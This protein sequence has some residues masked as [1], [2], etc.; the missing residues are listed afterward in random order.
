MEDRGPPTPVDDTPYIRFA[1]D[2]LTRDDD[3]EALQRPSTSTSDSYPVDRVIP[4]YGLGYMST[5][6]EELALTRKHRSTPTPTSQGARLFNY[7]ATRPLSRHSAVPSVIPR[8]QLLSAGPENFIPIPPPTH[9]PRHPD[10]LFLPTILRPISMITLSML[11][12]LM[13]VALM[14]LAIYSSYH[15]G[16]VE[17]GGIYGALY[18]FFAFLP[19][20]LAACIFVFVQSVM[21]AMTRI[22]PYT[23]MA[24]DDAE[25][26]ANALFLG[27]YPR[28]MLCPRWEG[29]GSIDF[30]NL[31]LFLS[32][33]T[34]PLQSCLFSV[35]QF[36]GVWKWTAVQGVAWT[37]VAI[38]ILVLLGTAI[39][40]L[41]F[42]R[43]RTGLLWDPR[44]LADII[45]LLGRSNSMEDYRDTDVIARKDQL[46]EKL[47]STPRLGYWMTQR[48]GQGIFYCIGEAGAATRRYTLD[49]G[50]LRETKEVDQSFDVERNAELYNDQTR[51]AYI[52]WYLRDTFVILW[53]VAGCLTLVALLVVSFLPSTAI[54]NGFPPLVPA[55]PNAQGYSPANFL[56]SFI[57]SVIGM[58]LYLW[59][60][61]LEMGLRKLQPWAELG[62]FNGATAD[63]SLLL[64]YT[65]E[66]PIYCTLAAFDGGHLRV[67][68]MSMLSFLFIL[69]PTISG[70]IF[71]PLTTST[72]EV[73]MI[74]N[75]PA[76]YICITLLILYM[77]GLFALVPNRRDMHLPH[78]VDCLAEIISFVHDSRILEDAAFRAPRSKADLSTRLMAAQADGRDA[79]YAFGSYTGRHGKICFGIEKLGRPNVRIQI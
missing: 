55:A 45:S 77:L 17:F 47:S 71:F 25:S 60:Q 18:F 43:R 62:E 6:R 52:A 48:K 10:L 75:R 70:G 41:F 16:L 68:I 72:D 8:R 65:A 35:T 5:H 63:R 13:T 11:C 23:L 37:L 20:I 57:P 46:R 42:F 66:L 76:F 19:Q 22:M 58:L 38:Y 50:K 74:P 64:D 2:Q 39:A 3:S 1:I 7:N 29:L 49:S 44:S 53:A 34:I 36:D 51:F 61:S 31:L 69:L 54:R 56:Y 21:S 33:F 79:R 28:T 4:D 15:D 32:V 24:M 40:A 9:T 67:A 26:R 78:D 30:A 12:L 59:F 14:F 27:L 73:S